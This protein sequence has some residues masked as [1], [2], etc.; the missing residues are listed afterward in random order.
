[1]PDVKY[2]HEEE[3]HNLESPDKIVTHL[4]NLFN[5]QSVLDIGCGLG[6]F[7]FAFK[8]KSVSKVMGVDGAWV[9]REL[10]KKY[11]NNDEFLEADLEKPLD[12]NRKFDLALCLEV[13]EHLSESSANVL[14]SSLTRHSDTIIFSAAIPLQGGQNHIN[15]QWLHYWADK[16]KSHGYYP[17]DM[18]RP[19]IWDDKGVFYWYKQNILVFSKVGAEA[20]NPASPTFMNIIHPELY[21]RK[22]TELNSIFDGNYPISGVAMIFIRTTLRKLGLIKVPKIKYRY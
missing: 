21:L 18:V 15:E 19:L 11:L 6:T 9:D 20:T 16:F 2:L 22:M 13:A 14:V 3:L 1:M 4:I 5:P 10:L 12:L 8:Q 7:L 17:Q